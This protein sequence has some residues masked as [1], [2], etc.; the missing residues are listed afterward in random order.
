M[1]AR[2]VG[3]GGSST[4][5]IA[6]SRPALLSSPVMAE[7]RLIRF[8]CFCSRILSAPVEHDL[9]SA[10]VTAQPDPA[11][12]VRNVGSGR[13]RP[14]HEC[15]IAPRTVGWTTLFDGGE[16]LPL[17]IGRIARGH[18]KLQSPEM[19]LN[20]HPVRPRDKLGRAPVM[21]EVSRELPLIR[22]IV[23]AILPLE[24]RLE[25]RVGLS[26]KGRDRN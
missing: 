1:S 25:R 26:G 14:A 21:H 10:G 5:P 16:D 12:H 3:I 9:E 20:F 6:G 23:G 19:R 24:G 15:E 17:F 13:H 8:V 4:Q 7:S 2:Q 22:R 11:P 18:G